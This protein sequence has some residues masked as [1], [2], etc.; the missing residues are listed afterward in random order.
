MNRLIKTFT[1]GEERNIKFQNVFRTR[2]LT[3]QLYIV[4]PGIS[5][6]VPL[7]NAQKSL[8]HGH[9]PFEQTYSLAIT[10]L[11]IEVALSYA[12]R[13]WDRQQFDLVIIADA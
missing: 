9:E 5:Y 13:S 10:D 3:T 8:G 6:A 4:H 12:P 2:H 7:M 1:V 11:H